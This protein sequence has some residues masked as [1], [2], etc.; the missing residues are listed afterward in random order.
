MLIQGWEDRVV[1]AF[2][3]SS[4]SRETDSKSHNKCYDGKVQNIRKEFLYF[5]KLTLRP[6]VC[7][8]ISQ[9]KSRGEF[10]A[11][12]TACGGHLDRREPAT[13]WELEEGLSGWNI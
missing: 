9:A 11:E 3:S 12:G 1:L 4:S 5:R 10:Q 7:A 13:F 2:K 6:E 8:G